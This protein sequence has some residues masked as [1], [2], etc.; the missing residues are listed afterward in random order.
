MKNTTPSFARG[1]RSAANY[2]MKEQSSERHRQPHRSVVSIIAKFLFPLACCVATAAPAQTANPKPWPTKPVRI[3]VPFAAGSFTDTAARTLG[4]ELTEALGQPV[5]VENRTGAGGILGNE[6]VAKAP[7]D[8]HTL[9]VTDNSFAVAAA[10]YK[11]LPYSPLGDIAPISQIAEAPAVLVARTNLAAKDLRSI[12]A[13]ARLDPAA[14]T[15]GSG[16]QGSSGHLAFE[17]LL[18]QPER[19]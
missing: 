15:F 5:I 7:A 1:D 4:K 14:M 17:E 18:L 10:L 9:L 11:K 6:I 3:V 13:T 12:I 2:P 8:G 19:A 16:G